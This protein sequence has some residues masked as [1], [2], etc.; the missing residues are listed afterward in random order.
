MN[1]DGYLGA[2]GQLPSYQEMK[3][4]SLVN[5]GLEMQN[6]QAEQATV[7]AQSDRERAML[8]AQQ[9]AQAL[10]AYH[11]QPSSQAAVRLMTEYPEMAEPVKEA[12]KLQSETAQRQ[13]LGTLT[14]VKF[15]LQSGRVDLAEQAAQRYIQAAKASGLPA[16]DDEAM[17]EVIRTNPQLALANIDGLLAVVGGPEKFGDTSKALADSTKTIGENA[18]AAEVQP[19]LVRKMNAE[20][21]ESETKAQYA[22]QVFQ[23]GLLNDEANRRNI[24]SQI[25]TRAAQID[26]ARDTLTSNVQLKMQELEDAGARP[27]PGSVNMMNQAVISG[28][29]NAALAERTRGLADQFAAS[30]ARGGA[31]SDWAEFSKR[32]LG[33]QDAVSMLRTQYQK[34]IN[35]AA[36]KSLPPG[37]ASDADIKIARQGFPSPTAPREYIVSWMKGMAKLQ[38]IAAAQDNG[39]AEWIAGNG[40]LGSAKRDLVVNGVQ[41][42]KGTSYVDYQR[43]TAATAG[44]QQ[45]PP[46][47]YMEF[48]R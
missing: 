5:R 34:L 11:Q 8:R 14:Q 44:R 46:R 26:I 4:F 22:P 16:E 20:A 41:I 2:L 13:H 36:I 48:A 15:A 27:D 3:R 1:L 47:S 43:R 9:R 30:P 40:N 23:S 7:D 32:L 25:T 37:P 29:A 24:D 42:P 19:S 33:R 10:S 17:V 12:W 18:R 45:L 39:R 6:Q 35:N 31:F 28:S 38:D 21:S